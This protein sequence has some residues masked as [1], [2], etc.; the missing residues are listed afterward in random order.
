MPLALERARENVGSLLW[1]DDEVEDF[2]GARN[3]LVNRGVEVL[4]AKTVDEALD[5]AESHEIRVCL[6]DLRLKAGRQGVDF[7]VAAHAK[8]PQMCFLVYSHYAHLTEPYQR[9][10]SLAEKLG[11]RL[12]NLPKGVVPS[13]TSPAFDQFF[14]DP[15]VDLLHKKSPSRELVAKFDRLDKKQFREISLPKYLTLPIEDRAEIA[16]DFRARHAEKIERLFQE[17]NVWALFLGEDDEPFRVEKDRRRIPNDAEIGAIAH[18]HRRVPFHFF[19]DSIAD[20]FDS[21]RCS[22]ETQA[23]GYPTIRIEF[24]GATFDTHFDTGLYESRFDYEFCNDVGILGPINF[25]GMGRVPAKAQLGT[26]PTKHLHPMSAFEVE[27]SI[28][29]RTSEESFDIVLRGIAT[30]RWDKTTFSRECYSDC[31][32]YQVMTT[33]SRSVPRRNGKI[34]IFR[35]GLLGRTLLEDNDKLKIILTHER[36]EIDWESGVVI[37]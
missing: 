25:P 29:K 9:L 5:T 32:Y 14:T 27:A 23:K 20:D 1:L 37:G 4:E 34:C 7:I 21:S 35:N 19:A 22:I 15:I 16:A 12:W 33:G 13:V 31:D 30:I 6:V 24:N 18:Q 36:T 8:Y 2:I 3:K 11:G 26:R 28:V 17:G 10:T